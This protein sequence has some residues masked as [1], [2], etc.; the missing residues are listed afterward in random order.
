M[1]LIVTLERFLADADERNDSVLLNVVGRQ[2]IRLKAQFDR[3]IVGFTLS[4]WYDNDRLI[5]RLAERTN[6][7]RRADQNHK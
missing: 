7:N 4:L 5:V 3:Q 2:H 1:G 6:P